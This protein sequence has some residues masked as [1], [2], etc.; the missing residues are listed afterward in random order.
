MMEMLG[1][2]LWTFHRLHRA[3]LK[4]NKR[5]ESIRDHGNFNWL[6]FYPPCGYIFYWLI[7]LFW[8]FPEIIYR[9]VYSLLDSIMIVT[10]ISECLYYIYC[11]LWFLHNYSNHHFV[12]FSK[13][14]ISSDITFK[15]PYALNRVALL[16]LRQC[17]FIT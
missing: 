6:I 2:S 8:K 15:K 9:D 5:N 7:S 13:W 3:F 14:V 12:H 17:I 1:K 16:L 10:A 4:S 11:Q